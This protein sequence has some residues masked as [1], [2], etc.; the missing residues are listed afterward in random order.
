MTKIQLRLGVAVV[1]TALVFVASVPMA[2]N[3]QAG[4]PGYPSP[5]EWD[6]L[7]DYF[8]AIAANDAKEQ[9]Q[10]AQTDAS[11]SP[12]APVDAAPAPAPPPAAPLEP[13][14]A[15]S[16]DGNAPSQT[17]AVLLPST[18]TGAPADGSVLSMTAALIAISGVAVACASLTVR[19]RKR[20]L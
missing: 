17:R 20:S 13:P 10:P 9:S 4:E 8:E 14:A 2:T 19:T 7:Y 11:T 5:S 6:L 3:V 1:A 12:S 16:G 18:G 15:P